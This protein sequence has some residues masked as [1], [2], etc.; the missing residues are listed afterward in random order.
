MAAGQAD[1]QTVYL[2]ST[3]RRGMRRCDWLHR[4]GARHYIGADFA[5]MRMGGNVRASLIFSIVALTFLT[6]GCAGQQGG[7]SSGGGAAPAA[8]GP[9]VNAPTYTDGD[10]FTIRLAPEM[11]SAL[12]LP[13]DLDLVVKH[14]G[15]SVV[16]ASKKT[17]NADEGALT[18]ELDP[19]MCTTLFQY[20]DT[21]LKFSPCD[22]DLQFPLTVGK[23]WTVVYGASTGGGN[24]IQQTGT[25]TVVGI[26]DVTVPAGTFKAY[27]VESRHGPSLRTTEWYV[28]EPVGFSVKVESTS[29][30]AANWELVSYHRAGAK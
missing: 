23:T 21:T 10:E 5:V 2:S 22:E 15:N 16:F 6:A 3:K 12:Q 9:A 7:T 8:S 27:R 24:L 4:S 29:P 18:Y 13:G 20:N 11:A 19:Q 28:P 17:G 30:E 26:E 1:K 14:D 25:G